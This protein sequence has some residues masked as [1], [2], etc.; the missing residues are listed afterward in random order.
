MS[1]D[2]ELN[3]YDINHVTNFDRDVSDVTSK[4]FTL[5]VNL[6]EQTLQVMNILGRI[7]AINTL[8]V[9]YIYSAEVIHH[10]HPRQRICLKYISR[11]SQ[12]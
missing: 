11:F 10:P 4:M 1:L 5:T 6:V 2:E 8:A 3:F 12:P 9:C 7:S